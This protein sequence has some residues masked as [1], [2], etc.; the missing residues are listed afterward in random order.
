MGFSI[1]DGA[2]FKNI[3]RNMDGYQTIIL[4]DIFFDESGDVNMLHKMVFLN[5]MEDIC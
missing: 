3:Y 5:I 4:N 2:K 1:F